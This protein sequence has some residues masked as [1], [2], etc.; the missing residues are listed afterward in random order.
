MQTAPA[1]TMA[2]VVHNQAL[3]SRKNRKKLLCRNLKIS[4]RLSI[5]IQ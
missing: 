3:S 2:T 4:R 5:I 1:V